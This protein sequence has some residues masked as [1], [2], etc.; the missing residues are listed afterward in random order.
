[1]STLFGLVFK[2]GRA[3]T[4][5]DLAPMGAAMR[6]QSPDGMATWIEGPAGLGHGLACFTPEDTLESQPWRSADG[7]LVLV[8]DGR[9]DNRREL[10][11]AMGISLAHLGRYP[12][13]AFILRAY[14][15]WGDD[16]PRHL[17]GNFA[18]VI[19]DTHRRRL[20]AARS[21]F[22]AAPLYYFACPSMFAFASRPKGL[23]ALPHVGRAVDEEYLADYLVSMPGDPGACFFRDIR[24]LEPGHT[25]VVGPS[26]RTISCFWNLGSVRQ[27]TFATGDERVEAARALFDRVVE[28]HL[29]SSTPVGVLM[30]GG[31]DS[32]AIAASAHRLRHSIGEVHAFTEVPSPDWEPGPQRSGVYFDETPYV[33]AMRHRYPDLRVCFVHGGG[34]YLDDAAILFGAGEYPFRN[35]AN[36]PWW[37]ACLRSAA[38]Q[39]ARV[40]LTGS[41]GNLTL[42]WPGE[43]VD[44]Q[45]GRGTFRGAWLAA[46]EEVRAGAQRSVPRILASNALSAMPRAKRCFAAWRL[47]W[48]PWASGPLWSHYSPIS[49]ELARSSHLAERT[50]AKGYNFA[51]VPQFGSAERRFRTLVASDAG[52]DLDRGHQELLGCQLRHPLK[53]QRL[54]EFCLGLPGQDFRPDGVPRGLMR[55]V[56]ADRLPPQIL[57][58]RARGV[59]AP[60][61][62]ARLRRARP[63]WEEELVRFE[64]SP[65]VCHAI[66]VPRMQRLA[67][68]FP[69]EGAETAALGLHYRVI[70]DSGLM[71]GRFLRWIEC[72]S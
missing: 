46:R 28:D 55:T 11:P 15:K 7:R 36:R 51:F 18:F 19:W 20:F 39:G 38:H 41:W 42:S 66:D 43:L 65:L 59:Q 1:M 45:L 10:A 63:I 22:G 49:P 35:A 25:L 34:F 68:M 8:S 2:D 70:F 71:T 13:S 69:S 48:R 40:L 54:V 72:G 3:A 17:V 64:K 52:S 12:D 61:W 5:A 29:R 24:R 9:V 57:N 21:P 30:S 26:G 4:G 31:L 27:A 50:F 67:K 53:D 44:G 62:L 33:E 58:N 37:E 23:F 16:S 32:T 6:G 60:D 14:E 56:M 47:G